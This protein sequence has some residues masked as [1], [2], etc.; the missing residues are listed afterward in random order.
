MRSSY[1]LI[2]VS[3]L[4]SSIQGYQL[5]ISSED[6]LPQV[7]QGMYG[8]GDA[9]IEVLFSQE[10][11]G[12]L[13]LVIYEFKDQHFLGKPR[14]N[15]MTDEGEAVDYICT[16]NAVTEQVCTEDQLG[17][18]IST[19]PAN[20]SSI[21]TTSVRFDSTLG[22]R[23]SG[24]FKYPVASTGYYCVGSIPLI[25]EGATSLSSFEGVVDFQNSFEG[26]LPAAE[27]PKLFVR[28]HLPL[29]DSSLNSL[30]SIVLSKSLRHLCCFGDWLGH[31]VR[32]K[33]E[34]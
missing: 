18:F 23:N 9:A 13:A 8:G 19:A 31:T 27:Y 26:A 1:S 12:E 30:R 15:A 17:Q 32:K 21:F 5:F 16:L 4:I 6:R 3:L 33:L 11:G 29:N 2:I 24:P 22:S 25:A 14:S 10:S 28:C 34:E 7:C 20:S